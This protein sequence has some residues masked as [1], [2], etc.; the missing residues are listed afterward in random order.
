MSL[1]IIIISVYVVFSILVIRRFIVNQKRVKSTFSEI[2]EELLNGINYQKMQINNRQERLKLYNFLI[3][4]IEEVL[5]IQS[6]IE[7]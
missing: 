2:N 1:K 4:N 7:L 6:R 5:I 3:Y